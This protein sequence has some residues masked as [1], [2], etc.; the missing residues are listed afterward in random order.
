[1]SRQLI[2]IKYSLRIG[3]SYSLNGVLITKKAWIYSIAW[4]LFFLGIALHF[5]PEKHTL[6]PLMHLC[7][8]V[9][10]SVR[11]VNPSGLGSQLAPWLG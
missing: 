11:F 7:T 2:I 10:V 3:R 6:L 9:E 1:M 4:A 5:P 8:F